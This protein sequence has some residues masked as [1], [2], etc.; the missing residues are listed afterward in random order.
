MDTPSYRDA[1]THLKTEQCYIVARMRLNALD[2]FRMKM[3]LS[4][5]GVDAFRMK[6][7]WNGCGVDA[8]RM[9]MH[10]SGCGADAST[11]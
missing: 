6:T 11:L 1:R 7:C 9:K 3:S 2:A 4:G 8:F 5:C 10:R